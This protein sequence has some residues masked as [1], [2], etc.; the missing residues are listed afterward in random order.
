MRKLFVLFLAAA[1]FAAFPA[2]AKRVTVTGTGATA[3]DAESDALRLAV[4]SAV[5]VLVDS[6]TL[7]E[8]G[9]LI[10]DKI[11]TNSRGFIRDY[12]VTGRNQDP[13]GSWSVTVNADVDESPDSKLMSE[14]TRLGIID[15]RLRN[16]KIAVYI[17]E[18]HLQ[19]RVP[20]PA[21]ETAVIKALT[22]AGFTNVMAASPVLQTASY[23]WAS[24]GVSGI[25]IEDLRAAANF[26]SADIVIMGEGF[27]E[28]VG[29]PGRWLPGMQRTNMQSCRAR[30]EA[31]MYIAKT[32]QVIAADGKYAS[33]LDISQAVASKKA[34]S[35]AGE[36]LGE[37]FIDEIMKF[38]AGNRQGMEITVIGSDFTKI[39]A[40]QEALSHVRGVKGVQLASYESGRGVFRVQYSGSPQGLFSDLKKAVEYNIDLRESAYNTMTVQV[41]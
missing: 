13:D 24:K 4:E 23:G 21:G 34:L 5:G 9:T 8:K 14:L 18:S 7:V 1:I 20:D 11:Y 38:G 41:Y 15:T 12:S 27:S 22:G 33:G 2:E 32:G 28:G 10:N 35:S 37:Y 17:P 6:E 29:D 40:V 3:S 19:Y 25:N 39:N 30:I 36:A 16:P 26:F 31:K